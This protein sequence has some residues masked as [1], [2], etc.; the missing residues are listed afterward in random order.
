MIAIKNREDQAAYYA[1]LDILKRVEQDQAEES[2]KVGG[3]S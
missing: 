3:E 2:K 1:L